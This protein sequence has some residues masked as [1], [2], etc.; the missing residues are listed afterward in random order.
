VSYGGKLEYKASYT[1]PSG[2]SDVTSDPDVILVGNGVMLTA[3]MTG[4]NSE[5]RPNEVMNRFVIF[6]EVRNL[7]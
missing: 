3:R 7:Q 2:R 1:I 5:I 4:P 6:R